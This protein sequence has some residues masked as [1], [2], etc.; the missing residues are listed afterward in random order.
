MTCPRRQV[1][2]RIGEIVDTLRPKPP[3]DQPDARACVEH[4]AQWVHAMKSLPPGELPDLSGFFSDSDSDSD[5]GASFS[6]GGGSAH[7]V[8][9][10]FALR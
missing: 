10:V 9:A 3:E 2:V 8:A 4:T 7:A 6:S 1:L 5:D